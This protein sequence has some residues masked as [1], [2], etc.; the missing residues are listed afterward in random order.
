MVKVQEAGIGSDIG[1]SFIIGAV[2]LLGMFFVRSF[3]PAASIL[4]P[5]VPASLA[6]TFRG[7]IIIF[8]SPITEEALFRKIFYEFLLRRGFKKY[9]AIIT[10]AGAFG[11]FH[12]L[13]YGIVLGQ[14]DKVSELIGVFPAV[15]GSI[16]AATFFGYMMQVLV[17]RT[18]KNG[19]ANLLPA[20]IVHAGLNAA[21]FLSLSVV[22]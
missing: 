15:S 4:V 14:L 16:I 21:I 17:N 2:T 11:L 8:A 19:K 12:S 3:F 9:Q 5:S 20:M 13:V 1:G 6:T 10:Q 22:F 7:F 18:A